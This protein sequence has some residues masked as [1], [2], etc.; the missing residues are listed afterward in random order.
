CRPDEAVVVE[1]EIEVQATSWKCKQGNCV[2][3]T[4]AARHRHGSKR[5]RSDGVIFETGSAA[6]RC[7]GA[8]QNH[9]VASCLTTATTRVTV[10]LHLRIA[11]GRQ[12]NTEGSSYRAKL[13][14]I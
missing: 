13:S 14:S 2:G 11:Q 10:W 12:Q 7:S 9:A 1:R 4:V 6:G 8:S 5:H 3:E